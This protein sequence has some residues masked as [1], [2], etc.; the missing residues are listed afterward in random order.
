MRTQYQTLN[1]EPA[2]AH[3]LL[4]R[5]DRPECANAFNTGMAEELRDLWS[6][7]YVEPADLRCVVLTGSGDRAFCAGGDLKE[8]NAMSDAAWQRQHAIFEQMMRAM[9]QC[10]LPIIAAVNGA[11]F[12]GGC[13]LVLGADF[14]YAARHARFALTEV[15]L[16]I[17]PGAMGTQ[18]LPRAVGLRRAKEIILSGRPFSAAEALA[19]GLVNRVCDGTALLDE[20]LD[21]ARTIAANAP[22]AVR[23]AKKSIAAASALDPHSGYAFEIEAYNRM[24]SSADR[25]EGVRAFN[26]R[27]KPKFQ[28][29]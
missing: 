24:V 5:L 18:N 11:A 25:L 26:E 8:R 13:E 17:M 23:Q 3:L 20:V 1:C 6:E 14:A 29:R 27:R 28:G 15:T 2:G 4:V 7:L 12:G 16:G 21:T 9:M 19:W 10:P 22:I